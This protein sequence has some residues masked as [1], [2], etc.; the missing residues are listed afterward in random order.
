MQLKTCFKCGL[1]KTQ[2][3]FY[4]HP[5][6]GDGLLGKCKECTKTDSKKRFNTLKHDEQWVEKEKKRSR[7]KYH[8]L[9]YKDKHKPNKEQKKLIMLKLKEK[10]PEKFKARNACQHMEKAKGNHLHH[11]SYNKEHYRDVIELNIL[12][13]NK[14]HRYMVY[15]QERMM[16][17]KLNGELIDSREKALKYYESLNEKD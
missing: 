15:D 11:W 9:G 17:R 8:R 1:Q 5:Q 13:H 14:I 6:M 16:Y 2:N 7:N 12:D 3:E 4:K 10:Y